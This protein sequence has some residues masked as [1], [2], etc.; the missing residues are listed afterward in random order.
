MS[1]Q[2]QPSLVNGMT[3]FVHGVC[4]YAHRTW[5]SLLEHGGTLTGL[6]NVAH[7]GLGRTMQDWYKK[8]INPKETVPALLLHNS[9]LTKVKP[10]SELSVPTDGTVMLES[11][12]IC[13]FFDKFVNAQANAGLFPDDPFKRD[14]GKQQLIPAFDEQA[15]KTQEEIVTLADDVVIP[16]M[17][18]LLMSPK[19]RHAELGTLLNSLLK[20]LEKAFGRL[21]IERTEA[22]PFY[23]GEHPSLVDIALV[24][25]LDRFSA[26]L[27]Y[28]C[29]DFPDLFRRAPQLKLMY[30]GFARRPSFRATAMPR[31]YY[32]K[33]YYH[34]TFE[35]AG[36]KDPRDD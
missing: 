25:F 33:R 9:P 27:P 19:D 22:K 13:R 21:P 31:D 2:V 32:L 20:D 24:P 1:L 15:R 17:Y 29:T 8:N 23:L 35:V 4:P 12:Q 36:G 18:D 10:L 16:A 6:V 7:P 26:A 28:Y 14:G 11:L 3:L 5:L 30:E 34:Y